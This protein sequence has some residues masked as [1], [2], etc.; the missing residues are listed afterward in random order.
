M[1]ARGI[2]IFYGASS[3]ETANSEIRPPVGFNVVCAKFILIRPLRLMNL[4]EL[5]HVW[6]SGSMLYPDFIRKR[7]LPY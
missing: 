2:S 7:E 5:E 3:A 1:S 4:L 6:G